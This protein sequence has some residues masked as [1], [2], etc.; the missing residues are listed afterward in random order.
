M[1]RACLPGVALRS[2]PCPQ[3]LPRPLL[4]CCCC[5]CGRQIGLFES[6]FDSRAQLCGFFGYD[7]KGFPSRADPS[8]AL[9]DCTVVLQWFSIA[10]IFDSLRHLLLHLLPLYSP[11]RLTCAPVTLSFSCRSF[12]RLV[13]AFCRGFYRF[14]EALWGERAYQVS[15]YVPRRAPNLS[16]G[17]S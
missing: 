12:Y 15:P 1:G 5:P 9:A 3:P 7:Y 10:D 17:P 14:V 2:T 13:E 4:V 11:C 16:R 8:T 6:L